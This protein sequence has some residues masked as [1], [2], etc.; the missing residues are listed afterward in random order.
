MW[1]KPPQ[2]LVAE[3]KNHFITSLEFCGLRI[4]AGLGCL[5][6]LLS[7][8]VRCAHSVTLSWWLGWAVLEVQESY[9]P[10]QDT[11]AAG[12]RKAEL[13]G[14]YL[15]EFLDI[16]SLTWQRQGGWDS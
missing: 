7:P 4:Q 16:A 3:H 2:N 11:L 8:T 10:M 5:T 13:S 1:S 14:D 12:D 15:P 9:S 6:P